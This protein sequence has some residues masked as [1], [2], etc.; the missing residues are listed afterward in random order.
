MKEEKILD[1][2]EYN[3]R[4]DKKDIL[5]VNYSNRRIIAESLERFCS[6][7]SI[8]NHG[9]KGVEERLFN[10]FHF[11]VKTKEEAEDLKKFID[12]I[13][14]KKG[15]KKTKMDVF[16][17][18]FLECKKYESK[19]DLLVLGDI[20]KTE[21]IFKYSFS[22]MATGGKIFFESDARFLCLPEYE[23]S[24]ILL[25]RSRKLYKIEKDEKKFSFLLSGSKT[26][27]YVLITNGNYITLL[28]YKDI[29]SHSKFCI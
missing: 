9:L 17:G 3:Y 23:P 7:Y 10:R 14:A 28:E 6:F 4:V 1:F 24:R 8:Y 19:I 22:K 15:V 11:L 26:D 20:E 21:E 12:E 18:N 5:F 29:Y 25:T 27:N 16:Y 13:L 2:S